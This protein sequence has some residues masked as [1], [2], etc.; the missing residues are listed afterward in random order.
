MTHDKRRMVT[1]FAASA[2]FARLTPNE[3]R[4][5]AR[6]ATVR[7]YPAGSAIIRE[8]D[9]SMSLYVVVS[10]RVLFEWHS[11]RAVPQVLTRHRPT[12]GGA[13][14]NHTRRSMSTRVAHGGVGRFAHHVAELPGERD[15]AFALQQDD[16]AGD[17]VAAG[18]RDGDSGGHA[19]LVA[20]ARHAVAEARGTQVVTQ[21]VLRHAAAHAPALGDAA[22]G[23]ARDRA[24]LALQIAHT[25]F[26]RILADDQAIVSMRSR[27][28]GGTGSSIL[29][30]QTNS[31]WLRS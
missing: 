26:V 1:A 30:V 7:V 10:G 11:L 29:A 20:F 23:L 14:E 6:G 4:R 18:G 19:H 16:L 24:D 17:Q 15:G 22:G 27:R 8:G 3:R 9:T 31:T 21:A 5:L 13:E 12:H 28:A 2:L 25:G